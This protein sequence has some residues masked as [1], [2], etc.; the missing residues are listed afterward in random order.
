MRKTIIVAKSIQVGLE[1]ARQLGLKNGTFYV[2]NSVEQLRGLNAAATSIL[3]VG[4]WEDRKDVSVPDMK[5]ALDTL[6]MFG[7]SVYAVAQVAKVK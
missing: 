4:G 6:R 1:L 3:L 2:P 5:Q 7:A